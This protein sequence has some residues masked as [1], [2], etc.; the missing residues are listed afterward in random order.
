MNMQPT[1]EK[2][3]ASF[4]KFEAT[5]PQFTV[6]CVASFLGLSKSAYIE[7]VLPAASLLRLTFYCFLKGITTDPYRVK[8]LVTARFSSLASRQTLP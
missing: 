8:F 4:A 1:L 7:T 6:G 2:K 5:P 3:L